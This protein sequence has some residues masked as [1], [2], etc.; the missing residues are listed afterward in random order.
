MTVEVAVGREGSKRSVVA[1]AGVMVVQR[2]RWIGMKLM[3]GAAMNHQSLTAGGSGRE[4][5][6]GIGNGGVEGLGRTPDSIGISHA[7]ASVGYRRLPARP[8]RDDDDRNGGGGGGSSGGTRGGG[9]SSSGG[10]GGG[11]GGEETATPD[12]WDQMTPRQQHKW[13]AHQRKRKSKARAAGMDQ[14]NSVR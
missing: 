12:N 10:T 3:M 5:R 6:K 11:V 1:A 9:S 4:L 8:Q 2:R 13:K 7:G 14:S